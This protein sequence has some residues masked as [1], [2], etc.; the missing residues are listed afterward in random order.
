M[1]R[2]TRWMVGISVVL[3][4]AVSWSAYQIFSLARQKAQLSVSRAKLKQIGLALHNYHDKYDCFPPAYTLGPDGKPWHSWR[5]LLLPFLDEQRLYDRYR[6]DE[7]WDGAHNR[8]LQELRPEAYASLLQQSQLKTVTT[9]LGVVSRRTMWPAHFSVK[10]SDVTDGTSNTVL[11]VQNFSSDVVW[12][13][14]REMREKD[15]LALLRP[16]ESSQPSKPATPSI[17][18]LLGD[19]YVRL[20]SPQ[21]NR[22]LFISLLMPKYGQYVVADGWP[23]EEGATSK[24]PDT[25]DAS[26]YPHTHILAVADSPVIPHETSVYCA[27]VQLAWDL[28]RPGVNRPVVATS[29]GLVVDALNAHPFPTDALSK[30]DYFAGASGLAP[31]N[32]AK[33]FEEFRERFPNAPLKMLANSGGF[34]GVRIL[35]YL[36]KS[37]PFPDVMERFPKPFQFKHGDQS[38]DVKSFGWPSSNG[39]G[40]GMAVLKE[41]VEVR[42]YAGRD[43][44]ILLL[45]SDSPK[46]D[47]IILARIKP[48][49]TLRATWETAADRISKPKA[50]QVVRELRG[51]DELQIPI[52]SFGVTSPVTELIGLHLPT[53]TSPDRSII[54]ARQTMRFRLDEYGAELIADMQMI[55]GEN[56]N[57]ALHIDPLEPRHFVFDGPFLLALKEKSATVP[58]FLAWI[59]NTDLMELAK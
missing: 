25:V 16:K 18:I 48:A 29:A 39:E 51:I 30:E 5:V 55:V 23:R 21:I 31:G 50:D 49:V 45:K 52:I 28:L 12:S 56:G 35:T 15:A 34:P 57:G 14:P 27:T 7:P 32:S 37:L 9:Y 47:E 36:Q 54:D 26:H 8:E 4:A 46:Q 1:S 17:P 44:F 38:T 42:D 33:L 11:L 41:T 19:G 22:D 20:I 10:I 24:L 40:S 58:Y 3:I 2:K 13:E 6:F 59:G 53:A 43:D